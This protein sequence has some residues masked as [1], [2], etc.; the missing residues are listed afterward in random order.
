ML[1]ELGVLDD[2]KYEWKKV[3]DVI[4]DDVNGYDLIIDSAI[5]YADKPMDI[6]GLWR[7]SA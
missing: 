5:G 4:A 6:S 1:A 7:Y 3:A 2:V